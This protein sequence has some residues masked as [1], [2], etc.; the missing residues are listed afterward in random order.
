MSCGMQLRCMVCSLIA[1]WA[2]GGILPAKC[3]K[4]IRVWNEGRRGMPDVESLT[5]EGCWQ[6]DLLVSGAAAP[7]A[8]FSPSIRKQSTCESRFNVCDYAG[9]AIPN[10]PSSRRALNERPT[11]PP[12]LV[13][14]HKHPGCGSPQLPVRK[15]GRPFREA[16]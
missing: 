4:D 9:G 6:F 11:S 13:T 5:L 10:L 16:E 7:A 15:R 3:L 12:S 14:R 8:S 1:L 2:D